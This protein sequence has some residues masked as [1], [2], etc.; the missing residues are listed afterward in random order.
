M[1]YTQSLSVPGGSLDSYIQTVHEIP[2]LTA[3][4]EKA[5]AHRLQNDNDL[6]AARTLVMHNLRFVI[7][8]ARG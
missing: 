8:V 2:V 5:V 4:E 6:N 1:T 7:K 3:E